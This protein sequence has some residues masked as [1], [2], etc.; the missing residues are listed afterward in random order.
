MKAAETPLKPSKITR[1]LLGGYL[2]VVG[3]FQ[4]ISGALQRFNEVSGVQVSLVLQGVLVNPRGVLGGPSGFTGVP[5]VLQDVSG[6]LQ[7]G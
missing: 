1:G 3:P 4:R 2:K 5:G 6:V 7:Q